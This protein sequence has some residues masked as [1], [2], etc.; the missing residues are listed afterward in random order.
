MAA[1]CDSA[2]RRVLL[3]WPLTHAFG[4][5]LP[6]SSANKTDCL[7]KLLPTLFLH[8]PTQST[9]SL[10]LP[11]PTASTKS[12]VHSTRTSCEQLIHSSHFRRFAARASRL[13][14]KLHLPRA[15]LVILIATT[16]GYNLLEDILAILPHLAK[17]Y[18]WVA[19]E[20][21]EHIDCQLVHIKL[22]GRT[23]SSLAD[24]NAKSAKECKVTRTAKA[25]KARK[26]IS[27]GSKTSQWHV[28]QRLG[29]EAFH[30]RV[31][32]QVQLGGHQLG[33]Q[34][35]T[36]RGSIIVR[37]KDYGRICGGL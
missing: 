34:E 14:C 22:V 33:V 17:F 10:S 24:G 21:G 3:K 6:L 35:A 7:D 2:T 11:A 25:S 4:Y 30:I 23:A 16:T 5:L 1:P 12:C 18:S 9:S 32:V 29:R 8:I 15:V 27:S 19:L 31:C 37:G 36:K 13:V 20:L 28:G 26:A